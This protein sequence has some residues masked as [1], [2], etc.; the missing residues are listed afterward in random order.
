MRKPTEEEKKIDNLERFLER[1]A[2]M[3]FDG[4]LSREKAEAECFFLRYRV[5][6]GKQQ[7]TVQKQQETQR[8]LFS[9]EG[10]SLGAML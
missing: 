6:V 2:I 1:V 4:G 5:I 9:L 8:C 7:E 10:T 3:E